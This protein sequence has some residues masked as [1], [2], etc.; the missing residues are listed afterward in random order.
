MSISRQLQAQHLAG[1][2][3]SGSPAAVR[4]WERQ[5]LEGE[6]ALLC[7]LGRRVGISPVRGPERRFLRTSL[8][9][10]APITAII[11]SLL[12]GIVVA[13]QCALATGMQDLD[14]G[15]RAVRRYTKSGERPVRLVA[16]CRH[17]S[18]RCLQPRGQQ[19]VG[20]GFRREPES[21]LKM[22]KA[23]DD[24]FHRQAPGEAADNRSPSS[25]DIGWSSA[26]RYCFSPGPKRILYKMFA[27]ES[28]TQI[29]IWGGTEPG[30]NRNSRRFR[31]AASE[32][33]FI[34]YS[35]SGAVLRLLLR[36]PVPKRG[37]RYLRFRSPWPNG[38]AR[39]RQ[40][41][42]SSTGEWP[43]RS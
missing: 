27:L 1:R 21:I 39:C 42:L 25:L 16:H 31:R 3:S 24:C 17:P 11:G 20:F 10:V 8:H 43:G 13:R 29:T 41:V 32:R 9:H 28:T 23:S 19:S 35:I 36:A 22:M 40:P 38:P 18:I 6:T 33:V 26:E 34:V 2:D 5:F 14:N 12:S 4:I 30:C 15:Y 37:P 7:V